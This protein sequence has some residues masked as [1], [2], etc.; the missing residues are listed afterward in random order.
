MSNSELY[1]V[2]DLALNT[3]E[4]KIP[5]FSFSKGMREKFLSF[6][7]KHILCICHFSV[8]ILQVVTQSSFL[9]LQLYSRCNVMHIT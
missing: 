2:D 4:Y 3:S 7:C 9:S 8:P 6:G 5:Q 1:S